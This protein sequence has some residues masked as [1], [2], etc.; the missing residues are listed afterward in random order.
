MRQALITLLSYSTALVGAMFGVWLSLKFD[1]KWPR[2]LVLCGA[3][4][5]LV[6]VVGVVL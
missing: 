3:W 6:L 1:F 4:L 5:A 2:F